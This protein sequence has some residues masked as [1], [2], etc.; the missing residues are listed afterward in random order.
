MNAFV[1]MEITEGFSKGDRVAVPIDS[2]LECL[3]IVANELN[4]VP[5]GAEAYS[6]TGLEI[7]D[8]QE[9]EI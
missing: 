5:E 4:K 7:T 6:I 2:V 3:Q 9:S 1:I 8:I